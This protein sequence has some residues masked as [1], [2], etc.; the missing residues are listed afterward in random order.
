MIRLR[1]PLQPEIAKLRISPVAPRGGSR[2]NLTSH[3]AHFTRVTS[4][5]VGDCIKPMNGHIGI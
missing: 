3:L 2:K 1:N 5:G 4:L